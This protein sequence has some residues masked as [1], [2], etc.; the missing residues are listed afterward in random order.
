MQFLP[1]TAG[2]VKKS[3]LLTSTAKWFHQQCD[4]EDVEAGA[5][6]D[7]VVCGMDRMETR[8]VYEDNPEDPKRPFDA[9]RSQRHHCVVGALDSGGVRY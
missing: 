7:M 3:E 1:R 9:R 5:F 6:H 4:A 2:V 8:L